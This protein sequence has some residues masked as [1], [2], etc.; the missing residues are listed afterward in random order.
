MPSN[1]SECKDEQKAKAH[2]ETAKIRKMLH[3]Q[4]QQIQ[5]KTAK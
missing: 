2:K 4:Q 5:Q 3:K 1:S